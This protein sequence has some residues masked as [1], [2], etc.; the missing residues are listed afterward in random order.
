MFKWPQ[1]RKEFWREKISKN[2]ERDRIALFRLKDLGWRVLTIWECALKGPGRIS[3]DNVLQ[4]CED[5]VLDNAN[6]L[7]EI[8]GT[9]RRAT[10]SAVV[11]N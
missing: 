11:R 1:T 4:C 2:L 10:Y 6:E 5:F 8:G 3:L 9:L 7:A